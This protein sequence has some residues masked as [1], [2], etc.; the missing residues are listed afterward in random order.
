MAKPVPG[1]KIQY[2]REEQYPLVEGTRCVQVRI[3]DDPAYLPALAGLIALATKYFNYARVD[4]TKAKQ[5]ADLWKNAY[6]L[7]DWD[8]CMNCEELQE[9]IQPLLDNLEIQITNNIL[10]QIQ[11]GTQNPGQPMSGADSASNIAGA[12]NPGCDLDILWAQCLAI[13]QFTNRAIV[14]VLEKVEV[15]T[16]VN[17]LVDVIGDIPGLSVIDKLLGPE[18]VTKAINYFQ[19]AIL[20]GY[21]AQYTETVEN[22]ITCQLFCICRDDCIISVD[23][24]FS[25]FQSRLS[26]LIPEN[27]GDLLD[28]IELVAGVDFDGTEVVDICFYFAWGAAKL[29]EILFGET[30]SLNTLQT[31]LS[32][33][34]DDASSDWTTLCATCPDVPVSINLYWPDVDETV[35][36]TLGV[37]YVLTSRNADGDLRVFLTAEGCFN[38]EVLATEFYNPPPFLQPSNYWYGTADCEDGPMVTHN[39]SGTGSEDPTTIDTSPGVSQYVAS[40]ADLGPFTMTVKFT[41]P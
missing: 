8:S 16:N 14:D 11:Y 28:L 18:A 32:L 38:V 22:E 4:K 25:L 2:L 34:V 3:P 10:N 37:E 20:E 30:I 12:T 26:S 15:A 13:V 21:S 19:E 24:V 7:T 27:P 6:L 41:V 29:G 35:N 1:I 40:N 36:Y 39:A 5:V 33:A 31:L 9:C 23:R 17:E